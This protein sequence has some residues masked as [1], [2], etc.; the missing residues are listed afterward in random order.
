ML[1]GGVAEPSPFYLTYSNQN[2]ETLRLAAKTG[3]IHMAALQVDG[4]TNLRPSS[5]KARGGGG[6]RGWVCIWDEG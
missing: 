5:A 2:A 4:R 3:F 1:F 6:G